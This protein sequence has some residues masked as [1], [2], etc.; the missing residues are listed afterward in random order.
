MVKQL[1]EELQNNFSD[2]SVAISNKM[3]I[4]KG[5]KI[6]KTISFFVCWLFFYLVV[7]ISFENR[8]LHME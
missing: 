2:H 5:G 8:V 4:E 7:L 3:S 6:K 1:L